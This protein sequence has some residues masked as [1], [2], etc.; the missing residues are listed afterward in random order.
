MRLGWNV[1]YK[2]RLFHSDADEV[3][4]TWYVPGFGIN[5]ASAYGATM[6]LA[7]DFGKTMKK[8]PPRNL[9]R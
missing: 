7:F 1:R 9:Y 6:N 2:R 3:G 5:G 8:Q 4:R